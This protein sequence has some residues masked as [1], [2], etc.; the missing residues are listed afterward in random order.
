MSKDEVKDE[1]KIMENA[2]QNPSEFLEKIVEKRKAAT[3]SSESESEEVKSETENEQ[4]EKAVSAQKRQRI[5]S[6]S[7][8]IFF[9]KNK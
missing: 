1:N 6:G 9:S 3:T 5:N 4:D 2:K 8:R 7:M